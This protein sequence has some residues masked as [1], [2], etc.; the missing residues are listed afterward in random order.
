LTRAELVR[1]PPAA[2][3]SSSDEEEG[4]VVAVSCVSD[5]EDPVDT[6]VAVLCA[7]SDEEECNAFVVSYVS[8]DGVEKVVPGV[9]SNATFEV[10]DGFVINEMSSHPS[11]PS[12][13]PLRKVTPQVEAQRRGSVRPVRSASTDSAKQRSQRDAM[14]KKYMPMVDSL[15]TYKDAMPFRYPVK[16]SM[17]DH[18]DAIVAE[19]MDISKLRENLIDAKY[20]TFPAIKKDFVRIFDNALKYNDPSK[21]PQYPRV[22]YPQVYNSAVT[23]K[24]VL[25][26][27]FLKV[28]RESEHYDSPRS[29]GKRK[30]RQTENLKNVAKSAESAKSAKSAKSAEAH[31]SKPA[32]PISHIQNAC[33]SLLGDLGEM[34]NVKGRQRTVVE[35][36]LLALSATRM[37]E[38][39]AYIKLV[40]C[41]GEDTMDYVLFQQQRR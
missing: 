6:P 9:A 37:T 16:R 29:I 18:Y 4:E 10:V 38:E 7:S 12:N 17:A 5:Y 3:F 14:C 20:A 8:Y 19:P 24:A 33:K 26:R 1:T 36:T 25:E 28:E 39:E 21:F 32:L 15:K 30:R 41:I 31:C 23:M 13:A 40:G 2:F 34:L 22:T 11:A 35:C 27:L